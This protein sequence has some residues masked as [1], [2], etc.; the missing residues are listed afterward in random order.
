MK[1][2]NRIAILTAT[3]TF[4]AGGASA[5][6]TLTNANS[7]QQHPSSYLQPRAAGCSPATSSQELDLNNVRALVNSG[8]DVWYD[9][10]SARYEVPAESGHT[11]IYAGSLWL[12]GT[13]VNGQLKCAAL[14]FRQGNDYWTGPLTTTGDAEVDPETCTKWD[15]HFRITR[16][17]VETFRA[18]YLAGVADAQNGTNTQTEDFPDY[19]VPQIIVNWPAH[20]DVSKNQDFYMAPFKD[21]NGNGVYDPLTGGDYPW[22]DLDNE[23]DCKTDRTVT[24]FGDLTLWWI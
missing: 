5:V 24:L 6:K 1:G 19:Q 23:I 2:I 17:E 3:L 16:Q 20:G 12:G 10:I 7:N 14:R 9:Q 18:W 15:T 4:L 21:A 11:A 13:D 22:Y 8:G